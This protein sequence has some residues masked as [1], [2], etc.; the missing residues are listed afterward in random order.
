MD[1]DIIAKLAASLKAGDLP[2]AQPRDIEAAVRLIADELPHTPVE[3]VRNAM[4]ALNG[5]RQFDHTRTLGKSWL[6][7][8]SFDASITK[9]YAQALI[10]LFELDP[11][12]KLLI[13]A[14]RE[15]RGAAAGAQAK[16]E[17]PEYLGLLG[18]IEK[19]RFVKTGD[20]DRL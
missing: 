8:R 14:L 19:Q 16:S 17:I 2:S 3:D 20:L 11:A 12:E 5:Q 13:D 7:A 15:A 1:H 4:K 6:E 18:R 10:D 9:R